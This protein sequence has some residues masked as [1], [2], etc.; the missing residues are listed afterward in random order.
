MNLRKKVIKSKKNDYEDM[1]GAVEAMRNVN[2]HFKT[3]TLPNDQFSLADLE[4]YVNHLIMIQEPDG[5]WT[6]SAFPEELAGDEKV[7]FAIYPTYLALGTLVLAEEY[8][9]ETEFPGRD[10]AL[11]KGFSI[12]KMEGYGEDSLF[13]IIE[14]VLMLIEAAVPPW[15]KSRRDNE[16]YYQVTMKLISF[17]DK[18]QSR[19]DAGDTVLSF[20]GDY[21]SIFE[22]VVSGLSV[23]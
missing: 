5:S 9:P 20:G 23:L 12:L 19:I 13:Q 15:L 18:L 4:T 8:L 3:G 11:R 6:V 17:R 2:R 21:R 1:G 16:V 14:M 7:E 10:D 22:L